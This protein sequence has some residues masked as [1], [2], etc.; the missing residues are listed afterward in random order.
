MRKVR[1]TLMKPGDNLGYVKV[2]VHTYAYL[3]AKSA[4][5]VSSYSFSFFA[6]E[7]VSGNDALVSAGL[8]SMS[9]LMINN[10]YHNPAHQERPAAATHGL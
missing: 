10:C 2:A 9:K 8:L 4:D 6:S 7:L 3:L 1:A 5:E